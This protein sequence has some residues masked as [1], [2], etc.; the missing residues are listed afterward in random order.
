MPLR[1]NNTPSISIRGVRTVKG[2]NF[3]FSLLEIL[4]AVGVLS[5]IAAASVPI[6]SS[7]RNSYR[8]QTARDELMGALET[9]RTTALKQ[10]TDTTMTLN[11]SGAYTT[12]FEQNGT[13]QTLRYALPQDV[14]FALPAGVTTLTI[15]CRAT[16][17]VT[18]TDNN[19]ARVTTLTI[20][21]PA[22]QRTVNI[23]L[24]GQI[25]ATFAIQT[26]QT[27]EVYT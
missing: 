7:A 16:G 26:W 15:L 4:V 2:H 13:V 6:L 12:Q 1:L 11:S 5:L 21:N 20:S 18:I 9:M 23:S 14:T 19:G 17:K 25:S 8:L 24:L 3:G 22:G 27:R 10:E